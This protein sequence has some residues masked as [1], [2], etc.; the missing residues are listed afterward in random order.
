MRSEW[1]IIFCLRQIHGNRQPGHRGYALDRDM[2]RSILPGLFPSGLFLRRRRGGHA[3]RTAHGAGQ[4]NERSQSHAV[5]IM[6]LHPFIK[7]H[8]PDRR[9]PSACL[10]PSF[11]PE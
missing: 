5:K 9:S 11:N 10:R 4:T 3:R 7:V 2:A 6:S 8:F 1:K